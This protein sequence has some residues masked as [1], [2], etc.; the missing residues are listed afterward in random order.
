M[1]ASDALVFFG[2]TGDLA[3]RQ[4]FP[5]LYAMIRRGHLDTPIIGVAGRPWTSDQLRER[6]RQSIHEHGGVDAEVFGKLSRQLTY[7][8]G[9]YHKPETYER[10]RQTLG[11][12]SRPLHYLAIPPSLFPTVIEGL[13]RAGLTRSARV[14]IEKPFGHDLASACE[15]NAVVSRAFRE[16]AVFRIDHY[17]G[18]E[19]VQN[20]LFF[21]FANAMLEPVWNRNYIESVQ[22]TMAEDFGVEDRGKF[23]EEAGAIRDV[24]QSH[25]LQVAA[26][27]AMDAPPGGGDPDSVRDQKAEAIKSMAP[28]DPAST[29]RGQYRGYRETPGVAPD[30]QVETYAAVRLHLDT[31]RWEGVPFYIRTGKYLPARTTEVLVEFKRPPLAVFGKASHGHPNH[32]RYRLSPTVEMG[33]GMRVKVAGEQMMG[34]D[35]ELQFCRCPGDEMAPYERLLGDAMRGDATLFAREDDIEAAWR[36]VDPVLDGATPL[37][38]YEPHTWGPPEADQLIATDG[39]W[40]DP[41]VISGVAE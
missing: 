18:K 23:Y 8:G 17:L 3:Y 15:L 31:W 37:R 10:L 30:S 7:L 14:V 6:A 1:E 21:R 4:I 29:V 28:L 19:A 22:I 2:A 16:P 32:L 34:R 25:M 11:S 12:A 35:V 5:A 27:L 9:D 13:A 26:L 20:I 39:G 40:H 36:V 41:Q 33:L 38:L 24:I